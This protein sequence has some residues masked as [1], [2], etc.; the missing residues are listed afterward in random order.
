MLRAALA[1]F[2]LALVAMALGQGGIGGM[3]MDVGRTLL[4][5]LMALAFFSALAWI[6]TGRPPR[7][8]PK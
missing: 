2:V 1:F 7:N 3:S 5:V 6:F 4:F 8:L